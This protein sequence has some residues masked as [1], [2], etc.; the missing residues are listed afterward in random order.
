MGFFDKLFGGKKPKEEPMTTGNPK[1]DA[2]VLIARGLTGND[3]MIVKEISG[4]CADPVPYFEAHREQYAERG[5][6][7]AEDVDTICWLGLVDCLLKYGCIC[8]RDYKD[9]AS[10]FTWAIQ[11]QEPVI[12]HDLIVR[13][14]WFDEEKAV[15]DWC[16]VLDEK[17]AKQGYCVGALDI[18]SDS[19]VLF[20]TTKERL[21]KLEEVSREAGHRIAA[22]KT[23]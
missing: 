11:H 5:I 10:D 1:M 12:M 21:A 4:F 6:T 3:H 20:V 17:W 13:E 2:M 18:D 22:A 7:S 15:P 23:M 14:L 8:E 9:S 16:A 19:Y